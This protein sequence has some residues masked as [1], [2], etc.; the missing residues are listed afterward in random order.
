MVKSWEEVEGWFDWQWIYDHIIESAPPNAVV[1]E[2]GSF[3]GRSAAYF[4]QKAKELGR[5]DVQ[6][7]CVDLWT[8]PDIPEDPSLLHLYEKTLLQIYGENN[9]SILPLFEKNM[10]DCGCSVVKVPSDTST[11][12][13]R[14]EDGSVYAVFVDADHRY[15]GVK[16]DL[17]AWIPKV[18]G[19]IAGHDFDW[20][21][22]QK[23]VFEKWN[24]QQIEQCPPRTWM[25]HL[26]PKVEQ[27]VCLTMISVAPPK[28]VIAAVRSAK[29]LVDGALILVDPGKG[30]K[31]KAALTRA[32]IGYPVK[33]VE[34]PWVNH[35]HN[36][37]RAFELAKEAGYDYAFTM[38]D[39]SVI[40][41]EE[42]WVRPP[43][44]ASQ[45]S[46]EIRS[47]KLSYHF[48]SMVNLKFPYR[49]IGA[50]HERLHC[51]VPISGCTLL[52]I[53]INRTGGVHGPEKFLRDASVL[54]GDI[55]KNPDD[56]RSYFYLGQSLKDA[57]VLLN[58]AGETEQARALLKEAKEVY[59]KCTTMNGWIQERFVA[60]LM[61]GNISS[62]LKEPWGGIL[63]LY[64]RA[65]DLI[66]T[67]REPFA[68]IGNYYAEQGNNT[69][70]VQFLAM[71]AQI[72]KPGIGSLFL[73]ERIYED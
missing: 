44:F 28:D 60:F 33:V 45:Y 2:L 65:W 34:E 21:G 20:G 15:E 42:G 14:Y 57:A 38:D 30:K 51:D 17:D 9:G 69:V 3:Y 48:P 36:R 11:A 8:T 19:I 55:E 22:V 72:P 50:A 41:V 23:A 43:L 56:Q 5:E 25:V 7:H 63:D 73:D 54:R 10:E 67:R 47:D 52:G 31:L 71:A 62:E 12:A 64:L 53:H 35:G 13:S 37:T 58:R 24:V 68:Y 32:K 61:A 70:A 49:Y 39:T 46:V 59:M 27:K 6:L 29:P 1:V 40:E 66:P 18:T 4:C 26:Q 16:K